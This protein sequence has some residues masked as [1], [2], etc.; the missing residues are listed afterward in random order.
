MAQQNL[1]KDNHYEPLW[2]VFGKIEC[3]IWIMWLC[4]WLKMCRYACGYKLTIL[5][6]KS[7][8]RVSFVLIPQIAFSNFVSIQLELWQTFY[9]PICRQQFYRTLFR[10]SD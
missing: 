5:S 4:A 10:V 7:R 1:K 3:L 2:Q 8:F 6:Q 9:S